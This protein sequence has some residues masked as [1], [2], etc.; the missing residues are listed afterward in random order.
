MKVSL[1]TAA[2]LLVLATG[3]VYAS[4]DGQAPKPRSSP[5]LTQST[6]IQAPAKTEDSG[7]K[8]PDFRPAFPMA[9]SSGAGG[10][11]LND[12][13]VCVICDASCYRPSKL[14]IYF[15]KADAMTTCE[16]FACWG[17]CSH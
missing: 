13:G 15:C 14:K 4:A 7:L 6:V 16:E 2:L 17:G 12:C 11:N 5:Q 1:F 9:F 8:I 10:A 3:S